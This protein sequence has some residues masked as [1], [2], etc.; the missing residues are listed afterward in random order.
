[1]HARL[2]RWLVAGILI[3]GSLTL[4]AAAAKRSD[5]AP[6]GVRTVF[7][8]RHADTDPKGESDPSL[9]QP[10][11]ERAGRLASLLR[12]EPLAAVFVTR[13]ARSLQTGTFAAQ[14]NGIEPT[15]Y[16][17]TDAVGLRAQI[18]GLPAGSAC[19]VVAHSNTVP[20]IAKSLGG[21]E[22]PELPEKEFDRLFVLVLEGE[23]LVRMFE[24]RY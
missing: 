7:L 20:A 11:A 24:L 8:V 18:T 19:L 23:R 2:T 13:T 15:V 3:V 10:G 22:M 12:D 17:P 14:H 16:P 5:P 1:M 9:T 4:L 6:A 21:R